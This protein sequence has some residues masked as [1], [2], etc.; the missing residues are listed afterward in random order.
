MASGDIPPCFY[1]LS[2]QN[3]AYGMALH[4]LVRRLPGREIGD[5]EVWQ[6]HNPDTARRFEGVCRA[7]ERKRGGVNAEMLFHG[8]TWAK[9]QEFAMHGFIVPAIRPERRRLAGANLYLERNPFTAMA[10]SVPGARLGE[11]AMYTLILAEVAL[12][13]PKTHTYPQHEDVIYGR[14]RLRPVRI[15]EPYNSLLIK[16]ETR[17]EVVIPNTD[18]ARPLF[19]IRFRWVG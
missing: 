16:S 18:Q 11:H 9:A 17:D 8:T 1:R 6:V 12:G 2:H 15:V 13:N 14:V 4:E 3:A 7:F 10:Y 19:I 5:V